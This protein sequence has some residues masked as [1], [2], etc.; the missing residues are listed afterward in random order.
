MKLISVIESSSGTGRLG[1]VVN[2]DKHG[3]VTLYTMIFGVKYYGPGGVLA[4]TKAQ[5]EGFTKDQLIDIGASVK[6]TDWETIKKAK[7]EMVK[8]LTGRIAKGKPPEHHPMEAYEDDDGESVRGI[9]VHKETGDL[10]ITGIVVRR[11]TLVEGEPRKDVNS[12][13]KTL[14]KQ[15]IKRLTPEGSYRTLFIDTTS[16]VRADGLEFEALTMHGE[17]TLSEVSL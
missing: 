10:Y 2:K 4:R 7:S 5:I 15:A 16:R 17:T 1:S 12:A 8:S 14:V 3:R 11:Q 9:R 13:D 6:V